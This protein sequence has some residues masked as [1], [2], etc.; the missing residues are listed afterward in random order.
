ME[1]GVQLG[2]PS[3]N[4][5]GRGAGRKLK[6]GEWEPQNLEPRLSIK[7]GWGLGWVTFPL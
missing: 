5:E 6:L 7:A 2:I 3:R 4:G 1:L